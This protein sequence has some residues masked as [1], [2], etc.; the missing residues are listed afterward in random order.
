M[1][2][3]V[4]VAILLSVATSVLASDKVSVRFYSDNIVRIT[5]GGEAPEGSFAVT[6]SPQDVRVRTSKSSGRTL[7]STSALKV[8][9]DGDGKVSFSTPKGVKLLDEGGWSMTERTEGL[10][11]GSFVVRQVFLPEKDEPFYGLGI[12]QDGTLSLRGKSRYMLQENQEDFVPIVQSVKG[13]G[14]FWDNPS[15]TDFADGEDGM[16]FTSEVGECVDYYFIWGGSA[17][18]V[19]SGIRT[20]TGEVPMLP[21][22]SYGFMQSRE[23]YKSQDELLEVLRTYRRLGIP[24][25]CLVQDWQYWGNNYLWNSMEFLNENFL[26]PEAMAKEVHD[27]GAHLMISVWS[28]FGPETKQYRE[29]EA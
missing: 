20:L 27:S 16:S 14:I 5:K 26:T 6:M 18:G 4:F 8:S 17:D 15:P 23:R 9:V 12:L 24:L 21:L 11:K 25:D 1:K 22:W 29:L 3:S 28:S 7:Y 19:I 2:K 13:Y 10:D